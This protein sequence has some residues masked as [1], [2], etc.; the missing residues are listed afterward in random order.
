LDDDARAVSR[1]DWDHD[2][3]LDFWIANRSGPQVR[4]L[5]N[6]APVRN[7]YLMLRLEGR[8]CNRDAIGA[9]VEISLRGTTPAK[10]MQT[11][12]A[13][14]GYLSQ[15]S[16]W[17][18]FGLGAASEIERLVVR[19]PGGDAEEFPPPTADGHY[20]LVQGS[21]SCEPIRLPV[22]R[23]PL[24]A[25]RVTGSPDSKQAQVLLS[26]P[27]PMPA[28]TYRTWDGRVESIP[29]DGERPVLLNLWASWCS[30]CQAELAEIARQYETLSPV[31]DIRALSVDGLDGTQAATDQSAIRAVAEHYPFVTGWATTDTV[32]KLQLAHD[33]VFE[34]LVPLPV[35]TSLLIQH[36]E[37]AA[38]PLRWNVC[39]LMWTD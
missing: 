5:R 11:L 7:H 28:L 24:A 19:W 32:E 30:P 26:T 1:V 9:R 14:D 13:G 12:R 20:R 27:I 31:V 22:V 25:K 8:T 33:L 17:I 37:L 29:L 2:G 18:H 39:W 38:V 6:D 4:F 34:T 35:P 10:R 3:D 23:D 36:G 15:S 16:K 21:Q